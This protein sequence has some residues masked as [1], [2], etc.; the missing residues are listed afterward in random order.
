M[1]EVPATH[2]VLDIL[3]III[4]HIK[5]TVKNAPDNVVRTNKYVEC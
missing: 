5:N 1:F 2:T 3:A 4:E